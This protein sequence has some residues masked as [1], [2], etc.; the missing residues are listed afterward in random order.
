[1]HV[2]PTV[3]I[4]LTSENSIRLEGT[5][6][7][8]TIEARSPEEQYSPFHMLGSSLAFCTFSVLFSWATH[9]GFAADDLAVD[10]AWT[11]AEEPHRVASLRVDLVWP[12]LPESRKA[13]AKR[14]ATLCTIH[15]TLTHP[16][17]IT[18]ETKP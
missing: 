8:M 16:P 11:F 5:T 6:G 10:V 7:P 18:I 3:K 9:A 12:S 1:M 2:P 15:Q 14:A 13:A 17:G 4:T